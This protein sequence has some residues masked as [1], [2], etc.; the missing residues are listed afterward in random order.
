MKVKFTA[1][2]HFGASES[3][4]LVGFRTLAVLPSRNG[5]HHSKK[6]DEQWNHRRLNTGSQSNI[7]LNA[8]SGEIRTPTRSA[9][10]TSAT[11]S[12]T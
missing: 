9:P 10:Q 7:V 12:V 4:R 11:A 2:Q 6:K 1:R 5:D 3:V 8:F